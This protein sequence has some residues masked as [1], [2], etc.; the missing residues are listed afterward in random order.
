MENKSTLKLTY[1]R[2]RK[3]LFCDSLIA[4]QIHGLR[5]YCETFVLENGSVISCKDDYNTPL[6]K[7]N[8]KPYKRIFDLHKRQHIRIGN[9]LRKKGAIVTLA[10]IEQFDIL[11]HQPAELGK[12][13]GQL[14]YFFV[15][16]LITR[17]NEKQ[18][19][20]IKHDRTF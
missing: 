4:D 1:L 6:T 11:L 3:C 7:E 15:E 12:Y 19:K 17:I 20:I 5:I 18:Y 14:A 13:D 8:N 10:D 16:F 9:L 2:G